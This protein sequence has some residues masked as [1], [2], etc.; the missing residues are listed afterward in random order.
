MANT[1]VSARKRAGVWAYRPRNRGKRIAW[2]K[3]YIWRTR[4]DMLRGFLDAWYDGRYI[5]ATSQH[6]DAK[7]R[8][9]RA[10][11]KLGTLCPGELP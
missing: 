1:T 2:L 11:A 9:E 5:S 6:R 8:L 3:S 7:Q 4:Q 10:K